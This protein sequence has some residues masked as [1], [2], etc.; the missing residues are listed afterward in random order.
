MS[1]QSKRQL[2][3][4]AVREHLGDEGLT[5]GRVALR[6]N[7]PEI[8]T[9]P[10]AAAFLRV[11]ESELLSAAVEGEL[12]GRAIGDEWRFS[13]AALLAWLR[14]EQGESRAAA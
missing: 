13:R 5:V 4:D 8:L 12:P 7:P 1:G 14:G 6:E 10:E 2:I 3:E 11:D 9:A